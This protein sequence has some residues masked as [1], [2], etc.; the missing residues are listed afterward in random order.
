MILL[1]VFVVTALAVLVGGL[2]LLVWR[3]N[4]RVA[5]LEGRQ[6]A[7]DERALQHELDV[8]DSRRK[9]ECAER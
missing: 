9:C 4:R 8:A 3:L 5:W 2:E 7:R 1:L 6:L